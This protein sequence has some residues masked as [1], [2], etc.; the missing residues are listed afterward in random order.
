M[1]RRRSL[2]LP[3][4]PSGSRNTKPRPALPMNPR[5]HAPPPV[6]RA[7]R[8]F[9]EYWGNIDPPRRGGGSVSAPAPPVRRTIPE[10]SIRGSATVS[11]AVV[12]SRH[13]E[14]AA[15]SVLGHRASIR[16]RPLILSN[17]D[18]PGE[19]QTLPSRLR[20]RRLLG[21][22]ESVA[23]WAP[24]VD[25]SSH[26]VTAGRPNI[27]WSNRT[28]FENGDKF[29]FGVAGQRKCPE[30]FDSRFDRIPEGFD[31]DPTILAD[32]VACDRGTGSGLP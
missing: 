25:R 11:S 10:G 21:R 4:S 13:L 29:G 12:S 7:R 22:R 2:W 24:I 1:A 15:S 32:S 23:L 17:P 20:R 3:P 16:V 8:G 19:Q 31:F 5:R 28:G 18:I 30:L 9:G 6:G 26:D 14:A 27:P